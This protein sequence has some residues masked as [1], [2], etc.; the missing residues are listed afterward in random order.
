METFTIGLQELGSEVKSNFAEF[1]SIAQGRSIITG[2]DWGR[3]RIEF[4]LSGDGMIRIFWTP[5]GLI[6]NFISTTNTDEIPPL[7]LKI[8]DGG[9]RVPARV[10]EKRIR[11][12]RSLYAIVHLDSLNRLNEVQE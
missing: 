1:I 12:L 3:D 6:A 7:I 10:I 9:K 4:G 5:T 2:A 8:D 11:A